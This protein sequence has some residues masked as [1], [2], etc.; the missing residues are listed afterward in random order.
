M[1]DNYDMNVRFGEFRFDSGTRLLYRGSETI[2]LTPKALE[3][4]ALL[5]ECRPDAISKEDIH[6]RLWATTYVSEASLQGLV[7]EIRAAL[8]DDAQRPRFIRTAH[9]F[10]YAFTAP[11]MEH[12]GKS[13]NSGTARAWL[14]SD[15]G[16][17][18]LVEGVNVIGRSGEDVIALDSSTVSR[19]HA[20]L[21]VGESTFLED[22]G[23]KNLTILNDRAVEGPTAVADGDRIRMGTFLFTFRTERTADTTKTLSAPRRVAR[24]RK[25]Q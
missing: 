10:G 12:K 6:A 18:P 8:G 25:D 14:V 21:V 5:L 23:S 22:L 11:V 17:L 24:R 13:P 9:G 19:R 1:N 20:R 15:S 16:R 7:S 2:H 3:L 4:L